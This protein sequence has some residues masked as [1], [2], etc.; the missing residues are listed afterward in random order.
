[1][2]R[3]RLRLKFA[4]LVLVVP[5]IAA[6]QST[7]AVTS[8]GPTGELSD[9]KQANEI[10]IRFSE[11]MVPLGRI[12][13][14]VAAPFVSIRPAIAGTFRW[15]GP[16]ILIFTP[17]PKVKLPNATRYEVRV[18]TSATAVS[19]RRLAIA[20]VVSFT[21]PTVRLL[22]TNWYREG[23]LYDRPVVIPLRFNQPVRASDVASHITLR[24]QR[25]DFTRP[26]ISAVV[27]NRMGADGAGRF[28]R[29]VAAAE[30]AANSEATVPFAI[31]TDWDKNRF[32]PAPSA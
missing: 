20:Y 13:D 10:R 5:S 8:A 17:D 9:V 26:D 24:Y 16:T 25:H 22:Q 3:L 18:D 27:R 14:V 23:G 4:A 6:A 11:P 28:D 31:A 1:M 19:G 7:L 32:E 29:K 15:A 12:P 30:A 2:T 21:T